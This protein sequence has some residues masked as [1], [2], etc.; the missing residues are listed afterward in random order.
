[1]TFFYVVASRPFFAGYHISIMCEGGKI[2]HYFA[3]PVARNNTIWNGAP[4]ATMMGVGRGRRKVNATIRQ[5]CG[6]TMPGQPQKK[7]NRPSR[8]S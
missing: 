7:S 8:V 5:L 3:C 2:R 1:M 4:V 6:R